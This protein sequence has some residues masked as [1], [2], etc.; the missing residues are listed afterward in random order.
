MPAKVTRRGSPLLR[1]AAESRARR[2]KA[3]RPRR[4]DVPRVT[5]TEAPRAALPANTSHE[6][7]PAATTASLA[8]GP[9]TV[10]SHDAARP[11]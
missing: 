9:R 1:Q 3:P 7:M 2:A 6:T 8:V 11:T 10:N 4:E 5:A